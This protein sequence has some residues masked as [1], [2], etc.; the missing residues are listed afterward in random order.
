VYSVVAANGDSLVGMEV[1]SC[2]GEAA[3]RVLVVSTT[4]QSGTLLVR[5]TGSAS[6]AII[7][8]FASDVFA[9]G[10]VVL[11]G[12]LTPFIVP[13]GEI[14]LRVELPE[15][16]SVLTKKLDGP[17]GHRVHIHVNDAGVVQVP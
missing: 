1:F 7:T 11:P 13:S 17:L 4:R 16:Q 15:L 9:G 3:D 6:V 2:S 14:L 8:A 12:V 5:Y 10:C